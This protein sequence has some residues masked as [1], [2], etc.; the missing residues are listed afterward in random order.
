MLKFSMAPILFFLLL[1]SSLIPGDAYSSPTQSF[2]SA[3][4]FQKGLDFLKDLFI[5][6]A[7]SSVIPIH[8]PQFKKTV[9]IP[10]VG[11]VHMVLSNTTIYQVDVPSSNVKPGESGLS[12]VASGT[13]CDLSMDWRYSYSNWLVP[14]E[15][16]D[17][18][19]ASV[20]VNGMEVR[21]TLGLELQEETLK[22][23]LLGCGCS[24]QDIS[25]KL[26]GGASWLYQG[27]VDTFEEQ[28]SSAVE[29]AICK[30]L[31]KG[32]LKVDSFL[33]AL[34]KEV[35]VNDNASFDITFAEKP[36]LSNSSIGLKINGL[37]REREKLPVHEYH[38]EK[39]PSASCTGPS[40]MFGITIDEA[41]FNSALALYYNEN[42]MKWS[43]NKVPNQLLLN[44]AGW[45]FIVPQLYKKYPNADMTLNIFLPC[46]PVVSISEHQILAT[47]NVDMIIDVVE[48]GDQIPVACI[49][50][51]HTSNEPDFDSELSLV[52][53][54]EGKT[55]GSGF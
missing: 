14:A 46:P 55:D 34:P 9:K 15:I 49:S 28:I 5:D 7:I 36:L 10:F 25:I 11:N 32:I 27:L 54:K 6:K 19:Q 53:K 3:V 43:M 23:F 4:I 29:K 38:F 35:Q 26:D 2:A 50:L 8:L 40:K 44:T 31:G 39:S 37:F 30:K 20:Q 16:S 48:G 13:T 24:V 52:P 33:Q 21:L 47:T 17:K 18:G 12:I 41:V 42:F 45:R 1:V 51:M 22:L